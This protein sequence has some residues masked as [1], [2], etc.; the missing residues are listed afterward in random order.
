LNPKDQKDVS[1]AP[2]L[3]PKMRDLDKPPTRLIIKSRSDYPIGPFPSS[4]SF[5][6]A[7]NIKL[8]RIDKRILQLENLQHLNLSDNVIK[9]I[10]EEIHNLSLVE[11]HLAGNQLVDIPVGACYGRLTTSLKLLDLSRNKLTHLPHSFTEFKSLIQLKLDC[12]QLQVLPRSFGKLNTLRYFSASSNNLCVLP[13][14]FSNLRLE[15]LDLFNNPFR[16]NGL[17]RR[18]TNLSDPG[19]L[20]LSARA[21]RKYKLPYD[22]QTLPIMLCHYLDSAK[23]CICG[24]ACFDAYLHYVANLQLHKVASTVTSINSHGL[25]QVPIELFLCSA[26]CL[27]L[28]K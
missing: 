18:H 26:K 2:L 13:F 11:L 14:S 15:S 28:W 27:K 12:N 4:L 10:P 16:A 21:V 22:P 25:N 17:L 3:P 24:K 19:L 6:M 8:N 7:A 1:V 20:E 5:I 23:K 9:T